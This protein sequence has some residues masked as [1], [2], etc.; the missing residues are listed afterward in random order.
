MLEIYT[1]ENPSVTKHTE[2]K[3]KNGGM[4]SSDEKTR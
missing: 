2:K 3:R 4:R 1:V